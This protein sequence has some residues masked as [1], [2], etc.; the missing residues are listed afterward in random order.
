MYRKCRVP[1]YL[2]L[3]SYSNIIQIFIKFLKKL[4][5]AGDLTVIR[6]A[7]ITLIYVSVEN[8]DIFTQHSSSPKKSIARNFSKVAIDKWTTNC[9][10]RVKK[11]SN[12]LFDLFWD[13][14]FFLLFKMSR[15]ITNEPLYSD[16]SNILPTSPKSDF[17]KHG[18]GFVTWRLSKDDL[19]FTCII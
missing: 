11:F 9:S 5:A 15:I 7:Q 3:F 19:K 8:S 10:P 13:F 1:N 4:R 2:S 6:S 18:R 16:K 14:A 12:R 17:G